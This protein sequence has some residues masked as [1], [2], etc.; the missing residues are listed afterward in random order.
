LMGNVWNLYIVFSKMAT[1]PILILLIHELGR[2]FHLLSFTRFS[3]VL[4]NF[5]YGSL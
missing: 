1:L 3:S 4:Y 5:H 2:F